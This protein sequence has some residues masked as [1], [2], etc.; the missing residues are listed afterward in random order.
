MDSV[1]YLSQ[2]DLILQIIALR[3]SLFLTDYL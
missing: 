1:F 3:A 2:I